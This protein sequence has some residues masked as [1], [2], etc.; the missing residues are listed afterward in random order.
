MDKE[1]IF[2]YSGE[3]KDRDEF[4][5]FLNTKGLLGHAVEVGVRAGY[6]SSRF[7][8]K[9]N[10]KLLTLVD[11]WA[12]LSDYHQHAGANWNQVYAN[13]MKRYQKFGE[14]VA[15]CRNIS[16]AAAEILPNDL[17]FVYIDANHQYGH[18]AEDLSAWWP[19]VKIGGI[20]AGHD[21]F[22]AC[23]IDVT[24]AV[25]NFAI[26][27]KVTI[28]VIPPSC[29]KRMQTTAA[30]GYWLTKEQKEQNE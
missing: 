13:A 18:V 6:F 28:S 11:P 24:N 22:S 15:V 27:H 10:G 16:M 3:V 2:K 17:D 25:M 29:N 23:Q 9:W 7:M 26:E 20:L 14:R 30:G 5:E 12:N 8:G 4:A 21:L 1:M 19:K